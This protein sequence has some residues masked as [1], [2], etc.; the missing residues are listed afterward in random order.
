MSTRSK[1]DQ[2]RNFDALIDKFEHRVYAS[3][4]GEWRLKLLQE[5]LAFLRQ[6]SRLKILDAGCGFAQVSQW[7]AEQGHDLY[8]T[9]VSQKMLDRAKRNFNQAGLSAHF[10]HEPFQAIDDSFDVVLFHAVIEWLADP[11]AGLHQAMSQVAEG[12]YL[13]LLFYN[14]NAMVYTNALKG[15][16]RLA[17]L[18]NDSYM[19]QGSKLTPPNPQYPHELMTELQSAGFKP[20]VQTGIRVFHDYMTE[21]ALAQS[22]TDELF[23]LEYRYC[24]LPVFCNMGRY[25]HILCQKGR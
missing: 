23:E 6:Q 9:D 21:M 11:L 2:D 13:S 25:V 19:G 20:R 15:A 5:D 4:K 1:P 3:V 16:W 12:G 24:R 22:N 7:F 18:L 8:L 17:P 14:R 10:Q